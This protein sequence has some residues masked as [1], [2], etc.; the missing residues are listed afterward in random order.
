M[1]MLV[2]AHVSDLNKKWRSDFARLFFPAHH[3]NMPFDVGEA[4]NSGVRWLLSIKPVRA[5][6]SGPFYTAIVLAVII[7][8]I[9]AFVFRDAEAPEGLHIM[10]LR[11]GF[12]TFVANLALLYLHYKVTEKGPDVEMRDLMQS[13]NRPRLGSDITIA[14][15][16]IKPYTE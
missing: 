15:V 7:A 12:W 16:L 2:C 1:M 4:I 9:A 10:T 6:A 8:L 11:V 13:T 3:I 14:P 5:V